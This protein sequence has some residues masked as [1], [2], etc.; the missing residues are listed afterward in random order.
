M[1]EKM[2]D[3]TKDNSKNNVVKKNET[4]KINENKTMKKKRVE[5]VQ[6]IGCTHC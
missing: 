4:R 3:N 5:Q 1:N 2:I 6:A